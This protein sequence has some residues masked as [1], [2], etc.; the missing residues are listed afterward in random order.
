[1]LVL[2]FVLGA[3]SFFGAWF[4]SSLLPDENGMGIKYWMQEGLLSLSLTVLVTSIK[5]WFFNM[6]IVFEHRKVLLLINV[7]FG[8]IIRVPLTYYLMIYISMQ[9]PGF[10]YTCAIC[11]VSLFYLCFMTARS[12]FK[13]FKG[14]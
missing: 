2:L 13:N 6:C 4:L 3:L 12:D 7:I 8:T 14:S 5:I 9:L 11:Q 10:Y 1:M